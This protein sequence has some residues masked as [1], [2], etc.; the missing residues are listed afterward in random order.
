MGLL[1]LIVALPALVGC[2]AEPLPVPPAADIWFDP[3]QEDGHTLAKRASDPSFANVRTLIV[4]GMPVGDAGYAALARSPYLGRIWQL[5]LLESDMTNLGLA[6]L[7]AARDLTPESISIGMG[8]FDHRGWSL[9]L[10]S[11]IL[12]VTTRLDVVGAA[13][14]D[15]GAIEL[16]QSPQAESLVD[17]SMSNCRLTKRGIA[18]I[19]TSRRLGALELLSVSEREMH[20]SPFEHLKDP[21]NLPLLRRLMLPNHRL[22]PATRAA[23]EAARPGLTILEPHP[24]F[25]APGLVEATE[26]SSD[27]PDACLDSPSTVSETPTIEAAHPGLTVVHPDPSS[28]PA[29]SAEAVS[30]A[31]GRPDAAPSSPSPPPGRPAAGTTSRPDHPPPRD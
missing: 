29:S 12:S 3:S 7:S 2:E 18:A 30:P 21:T 20:L 13:I 9:L 11:P 28:A 4:S 26:S 10:Q 23:I 22:P 15:V 24:A 16:G 17:L 5:D 25:A 27:R 6:A 1:S 8:T 14:G 31:G 19:L